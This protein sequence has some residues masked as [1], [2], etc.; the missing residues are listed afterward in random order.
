MLFSFKIDKPVN[1]EVAFGKVKEELGSLGGRLDGDEEKGFISVLGT[2]GTY[3]VHVDC[4]EIV[5]LKKM[6]PL[7]PN[8]M[9]EKEIRGAFERLC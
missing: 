8:R 1:M 5:V 6:S 2:E 7:I 4:I 3:A 9:I